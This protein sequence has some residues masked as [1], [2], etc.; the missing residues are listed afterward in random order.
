MLITA[1]TW[2]IPTGCQWCAHRLAVAMIA[3]TA[4]LSATGVAA[5]DHRPNPGQL[6]TMARPGT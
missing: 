3:S 6:D 4:M 5:A 1:S 2:K